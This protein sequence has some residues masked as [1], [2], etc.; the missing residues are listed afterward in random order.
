MPQIICSLFTKFLDIIFP[1]KCGF[2]GK[3][4]KDFICKKCENEIKYLKKDCIA[5]TNN[6]TYKYHL[7]AYKYENEIREKML[8]FKFNDEP[9]LAETFSKLIIKNEKIC[10]FLETYDIII[11]VPMHIKKQTIRGYNQADLIAKKIAKEL[12]IEYAK[13]AL[14]KIRK[15]KT[16]SSL[17]ASQRK[18][19]VKDAY[20]C[21]IKEK[22]KD[23]K[24]IL[25]DDIY[26]TG[27]TVAECAKVLK[28]SGAKEISVFT[29]AKD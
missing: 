29:F 3:I 24:V 21:K 11:P 27:S 15:T 8:Q 20:D 1:P 7:Y 25:F 14:I 18:S 5:K 2:C 28:Q 26:T 10:R 9:E 6:V 4:N 22:I 17:N 19:N 23:K 13:D 16:Q 12:H